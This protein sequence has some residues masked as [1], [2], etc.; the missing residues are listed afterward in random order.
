MPTSHQSSPLEPVSAPDPAKAPWRH[1]LHTI[2]FEADTP[3]GRA[4]DIAIIT[5]VVLVIVDSMG[6]LTPPVHRA[7]FAAEWALTI[8]FTIEYIARLVAVRQP[9]RYATSFFGI[10][11]LLAIVPAYVGLFVPGGR[12]LL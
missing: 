11:D 6:G 9:V 3:A 7:L 1:R 8:L 4:F 10:V 12:Y 2:I 5:S